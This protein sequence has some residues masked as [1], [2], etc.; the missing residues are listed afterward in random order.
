MET[1]TPQFTPVEAP[2]KSNTP[3]IIGIVVVVVLCC[4]CLLV[5]GGLL[6]FMGKSV[7]G[8]YSSINE[9]LTAMPNIPSVP[10]GTAEPSN[11]SNPSDTPSIPTNLVPQGGLGDDVLRANT[12]GYVIAAA[13]ISGCTATDASKTD[14]E[15][16]EQPDSAGVWKEKWT[17]TC[18]DESNKSFDVLFTPNKQG[19]TDINVT[20][21]K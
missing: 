11:P 7:G 14:I 15:V 18:D 19:G 12:W 2:K 20:S 1:P 17:V 16:L 13:A 4:C 3:L 9:Q 21:S 10:A 8:V 5:G 6:L